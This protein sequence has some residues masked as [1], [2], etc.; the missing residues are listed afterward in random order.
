M[1]KELSLLTTEAP[2]EAMLINDINVVKVGW[3]A[4]ENLEKRGV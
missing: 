3:E 2:R 1:M 4:M